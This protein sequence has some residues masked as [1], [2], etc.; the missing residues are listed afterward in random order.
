MTR[1]FKLTGSGKIQFLK[2]KTKQKQKQISDENFKTLL[3]LNLISLTQ[4]VYNFLSLFFINI[5]PREILMYKLIPLILDQKV[6]YDR[7]FKQVI[8]TTE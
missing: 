3:N 6:F 7:A 1:N 5:P 4:L 8:D 2:K